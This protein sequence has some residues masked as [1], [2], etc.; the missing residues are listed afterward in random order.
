MDLQDIITLFGNETARLKFLE[1]CKEYYA[2]RVKQ[3]AGESAGIPVRSSRR[4]EIHT[5]IMV[6]VQKLFLSRKDPM[7]SRKEVGVM[8]MEYFRTEMDSI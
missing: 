1:L 7:P 6:I 4:A 3:E 2:E 8:I 5:Q